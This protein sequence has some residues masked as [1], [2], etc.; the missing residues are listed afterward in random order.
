MGMISKS[1]QVLP[2]QA[3][4]ID[5]VVHS[6]LGISRAQLRGLFDRGC[7]QLNQTPCQSGAQRVA[8]GDRVDVR[9]DPNQNYAVRDNPWRDSGFRVVF[10][11]RWLIVV[12]KAAELLT[13]PNERGARG[14]LV[15]RVAE[16][17]WRKQGVRRLHVIQ[18]LDRGVGGLVVFAKD[19]ES[20]GR[21]RDQFRQ[22]KAGRTYVAIVAGR[23][24]QPAGTFRSHLATSKSLNR[25][26]TRDERRGE[27]A[28]THYR[29]LRQLSDCAVVEIRLETGK[30]NQI[31]VHFAEA[32]HPL[33]GDRRYGPGG[34]PVARWRKGRIALH[35]TRLAFQHP[36]SLQPL[37]L[38][39][40]LPTEFQSRLGL[41]APSEP[42][43][44]DSRRTG[45]DRG[46]SR[47]DPRDS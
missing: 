47:S 14:S 19:R 10:E 2:D 18:R 46:S 20:A 30:R 43:G 28:V 45:M 25:Y 34:S 1:T 15:D 40:P 3:G 8:A 5:R 41:P 6:L 44:R 13:V 37:E 17:V 11:D 22:R 36:H 7:V 38:E 9:Y 24:E 27:L 32:G 21:L 4:R 26:S 42:R 33:L 12:D 39:S 35:A 29:V 23:L 31:R 16:Y